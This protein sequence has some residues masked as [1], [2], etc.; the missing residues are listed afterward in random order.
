[1]AE[2]VIREVQLVFSAG[3]LFY[4]VLDIPRTCGLWLS[5]EK[6]PLPVP[7]EWHRPGLTF[8]AIMRGRDYFRIGAYSPQ[9]TDGSKSLPLDDELV[10]DWCDASWWTPGLEEA[11]GEIQGMREALCQA[12]KE[13]ERQAGKPVPLGK[14]AKKG[15]K[16]NA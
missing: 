1:M 13:K 12:E 8:A 5:I 9:H 15:E 7:N 14:D 2:R 6:H 3:G 11:W 10:R 4:A 16:G